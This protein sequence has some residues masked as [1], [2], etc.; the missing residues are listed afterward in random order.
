MS[1]IC[2]IEARPRI[3]ATGAEEV[4]RLA[5]GGTDAEYYRGGQHYR[6]GIVSQPRFRAAFGFDDNGW[7]GGTVPTNGELGFAPGEGALVDALTAYYWRDAAITIDAGDEHAALSR[8]L[9]GTVAGVAAVD[10]QLGFT[11]TDPAKLIDKPIVGPGFAGT[12]GIEGPVEATGRVKRRSW[13][14]LFNVPGALLDKVNNI[15]EFGDP[16]KPWQAF[17]AVR[18]MGRAGTVNVLAWQGSIAA[19]FAALQAAAA[20]QGGGVAA[21]SIACV[22]WWTQPAGPLTADIRGETAGGYAS[23]AVAIAARML[24]AVGGPAI[25]D[26]AAAEAMRPAV[27]GV[28]IASDSDTVAQAIDRLFLGSSLF[29]V[30][31]PDGT[32]RVGEWAWKAP[33]A[34]FEAQF[35]GRERQ[36]PPVKSRKV[37]YRR[38]HQLHQASEIS[39]AA[40][41]NLLV[42][43]TPPSADISYPGQ[44]WQDDAA[45]YWRR[46]EDV[47]LSVGGNR[48]MV[49][50]NL[51]TVTWEPNAL[52]PVRDGINNGM[53]TV[54]IEVDAVRQLADDAR[55]TA[56][57]KV[58][59]F[60][61]PAAPIAEGEGDLWFDTDDGNKQYRW[62][63]AV[64]VAVQ[65]TAIGDA[66]DA[67]AAADAKADGKVTTFFAEAAPVAEA[68]G[69]LWFKGS[70][71]E[72]RRWNAT[73]GV[74]GDALVDLTAAAQV[75]IVPA[76]TFTLYRTSAGAVK[77]EQLPA[78]LRPLVTVGGVDKRT[79]N[80]FAYTVAGFGGLAGKVTVNT[81]NG[82]AGKGD[83]TIADTVTGEG[84]FELS[85][86]KSGVPVGTYTTQVQT[87]DDLPPINNAGAGGTDTTLAAITSTAYDTMTGQDAGDPLL[88]VV[89]AGP[90]DTLK[91]AANFKYQH[92]PATATGSPV[93]MTCKAECSSDNWATVIAMDGGGSDATGTASQAGIVEDRVKGELIHTFTKTGLAA[94][95]YKV[96]L[97]G[98]KAAAASGSLQVQSGSATSSKS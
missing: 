89:V 32:V 83:V 44:L 69:D 55:A 2:F 19:T 80:A 85:V 53:A 34:T 79:D 27:C 96:R 24:A 84:Y 25:A 21:P 49:G 16:S 22:K 56:D 87:V 97:L 61:Q 40:T 57:G 31:Q 70:T 46:R 93:A 59:S 54:R 17:D 8:R 11:I 39:V 76:P 12:G 58:Q 64:W 35:I 63:G 5:G 60:Y 78:P 42:Q 75:V 65:D 15:Y 1:E 62:S 6:A 88:D 50:G 10:G 86:T 29:W 94:G 43:P 20:P 91:L 82:S 52:Q 51:L 41:G 92:I 36:L 9:T 98:K 95:T 38:N 74:W 77:S 14:Q 3:I 72:L 37:G 81:T 45:N 13:G 66:L 30:L 33:V 4:V 73:D 18:D 7:T 67:A 28:H 23:S 47:H 90:G 71:G 68:D 26:Q 48:I